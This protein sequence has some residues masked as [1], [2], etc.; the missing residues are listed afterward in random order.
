[1]TV[2]ALV[3]SL[4][5]NAGRGRRRLYAAHLTAFSISVLVAARV[6]VQEFPP[7]RSE[8]PSWHIVAAL[9]VMICNPA[10]VLIV[11]RWRLLVG[12]SG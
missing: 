5:R 11:G 6:M 4:G 7:Q 3:G 8:S 10:T 1:M 12:L 9:W 2:T